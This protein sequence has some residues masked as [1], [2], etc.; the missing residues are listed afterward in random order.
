MLIEVNLNAVKAQN[1]SVSQY[2][3]LYLLYRKTKNLEELL[4]ILGLSHSDY[5]LL[6]N[7][8]LIH[9]QTADEKMQ[10]FQLRPSGAAIF[11]TSGQE[12]QMWA[13]FCTHMPFKVA[14]RILR[15]K[16]PD[17][18]SNKKLKDKYLRMVKHDQNIHKVV[19]ACIDI[20]LEVERHKLQYL[21][22]SETWINQ[23]TWEKYLHIYDEEVKKGR[24]RTKENTT[25]I[26]TSQSAESISANHNESTG[27]RRL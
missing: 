4:P 16:D 5:E 25:Q 8:N 18:A 9:T 23:R 10:T 19:I 20:Q 26:N 7:R 1:L 13:E 27:E 6:S 15:T 12:D 21:Q 14:D 3:F 2:I 24:D 11:E 17:A 22:N